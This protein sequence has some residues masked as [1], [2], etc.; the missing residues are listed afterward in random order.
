[1]QRL[2]PALV[3]LVIVLVVLSSCMFVVRE[4][5]AVLVFALGEVRKT[6]TDP[7]LYFKLPPPL[8]TI[9]RLDKRLQTIETNDPERI[10]TAEKKNLLIDSFV[11]W[12]IDDARLFYVT[13]GVNDRAAVERLQA[14][15]R[16]ALNAAVNVRTV[17]EVVSTER[18]TIMREILSTVQLR[19]KPL[20]V[21]VVD[22]RL[23]RIEFTPEISESVYRRM[24]AE[25]K[26]EA[27]RLRASGAADGERIRAQADRQRQE[28]LAE[29]FAKAQA[30]RGEG[31]GVAAGIY[32]GAFGKN[33]QFFEFYRSL[34]AYSAAFRGK[35]D[36][37]VISP[38]SEFFRFWGSAAG[39]GTPAAGGQP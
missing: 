8:E 23:R 29:A 16:D 13:F 38:N 34:E 22:V 26:Q 30:V 25:R 17:K 11:K 4:R 19:A 20:G 12:R 14:Q 6:I 18:D 35:G 3:G 1:M 24:E 9:T 7:G 39:T 33:P 32:A 27:N 28:M 10:Q 2:F 15:I 21:E 5:D 37:L 31:E 36:T